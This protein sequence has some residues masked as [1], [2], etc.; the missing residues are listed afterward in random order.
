MSGR[1]LHPCPF[2]LPTAEAH[3]EF[4]D[5]VDVDREDDDVD[6]EDDDADREDDDVDREDDDVDREDDDVDR[7]DDGV[8][9]DDDMSR[10]DNSEH[11][12]TGREDDAD[13]EDDAMS[14]ADDDASYE[15]D[16]DRDGS[17]DPEIRSDSKALANT[18]EPQPA[19]AGSRKRK[20]NED[21]HLR[22]PLVPLQEG[23]APMRK[24]QR[25]RSTS[26]ISPG[27]PQRSL[28]WS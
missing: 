25:P 14:R 24:I 19:A 9:H 27:R 6:R 7:E 22:M 1:F 2:G 16:N 15:D 26:R 4:D 17:E 23:A 28:I 11:T 18:Q 20:R 12:Y 13:R 3:E 8:D 21:A 10:E 5:Y